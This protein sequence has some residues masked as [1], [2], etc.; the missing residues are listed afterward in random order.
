[1]SILSHPLTYA[2]LE[3]EREVRDER[4]ELIEGEIVVTPSPTAWHQLISHR[5][6]VALDRV[7]VEPDLGVV[8]AA[9]LDVWFDDFNVLQP[10][11]IVLLHDRQE[12]FG[13]AN[14]EG[15]PNLAIEILSPSTSRRDRGIKRD[16][17]ARFGVE[18][19]W[20]VDPDTES[21]TVFSNLQNGQYEH[22]EMSQ[23]TATSVVIP[24]FFIEMR[25]LF[26]P[27]RGR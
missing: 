11:L 20:L 3:R 18:E 15:A 12:R 19:Y 21:A 17:Y 27:V 6:A 13:R 26:V 5:L 14:I 23:K 7:V 10:D 9:P 1:M 4:L 2:D 8:L 24:S 16:L 25:V 22:T